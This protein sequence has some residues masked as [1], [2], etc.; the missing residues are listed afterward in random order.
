MTPATSTAPAARPVSEPFDVLAARW[1]TDKGAHGYGRV[2]DALLGPRRGEALDLLEVGVAAGRSLLLWLD[3]LPAAHVRGLDRDLTPRWRAEFCGSF[4]LAGDAD[5]AGRLTLLRG[6]QEDWSSLRRL[7]PPGS[8]DV[9]IDDA[10]HR[11]AD[12]LVTALAL[13]PA[14]RPGGLYFVEDVQGPGEQALL[15]QLPGWRETFITGPRIDDRLL[16]LEKPAP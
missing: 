8:L 7:F 1:G 14:L 11:P 2:Y 9:V 6:H 12:Q 5:R 16:M 10:S 15:E 3:W 4:G 13:W